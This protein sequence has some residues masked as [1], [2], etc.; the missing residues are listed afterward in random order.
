MIL[1]ELNIRIL[2]S[3]CRHMSLNHILKQDSFKGSQSRVNFTLD[4]EFD[5]TEIDQTFKK[6][7]SALCAK[8]AEHLLTHKLINY[9]NAKSFARIL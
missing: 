9:G 7:L 8:C 5:G 4:S 6:D 3:K 2:P 1:L